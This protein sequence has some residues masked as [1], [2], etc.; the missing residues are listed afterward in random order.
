MV[1]STLS[2]TKYSRSDIQ[3]QLVLNMF[4]NKKFENC[5]LATQAE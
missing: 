3:R 1:D 4:M 2:H 5:F